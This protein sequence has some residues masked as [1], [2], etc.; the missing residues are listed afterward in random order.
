[1]IPIK[2]DSKHHLQR[3]TSLAA[4]VLP[5]Q[6]T[7]IIIMKRFISI[8]FLFFSIA[9]K[10]QL[11]SYTPLNADFDTTITIQFNLNLSQG[12]KASGLL[13]KTDGLYLWAGAGISESNA[14]EFTPKAQYNFNAPVEGGKLTSLGGNRWEISINPKTLPS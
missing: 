6:S 7:K 11:V 4:I 3:S 13:G 12:E 2:N 9:I 8:V 1:L 14:F 10:A 5:Y